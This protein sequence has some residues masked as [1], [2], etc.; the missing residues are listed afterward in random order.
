M[1]IKKINFRYLYLSMF[2]GLAW[3]MLAYVLGNHYFGWMEQHALFALV[4]SP[5]IGLFAGAVFTPEWS[6]EDVT[7]KIHISFASL[8]VTGIIFI[9]SLCCIGHFNFTVV[10]IIST[11]YFLLCI[12][13]RF[14]LF[15][16]LLLLFVIPFVILA[17]MNHSFIAYI[18]AED[19]L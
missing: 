14:P 10:D 19:N 16:P 7:T 9:S 3:G 5:L 12:L 18:Y 15:F 6:D 17:Y 1:T 2:T 4:V 13:I 8:I 11:G